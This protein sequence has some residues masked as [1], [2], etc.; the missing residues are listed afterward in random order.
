MTEVEPFAS[1]IEYISDS[2]NISKAFLYT[3]SG[4]ISL[5]IYKKIKE[6]IKSK[7]KLELIKTSYSQLGF[8]KLMKNDAFL[9]SFNFK[10]KKRSL[11]CYSLPSG[12]VNYGNNCYVN[13]F[14]QCISSLNEFIEY[15]SLEINSSIVSFTNLLRDINCSK[16][17]ILHP[18]DFISDICSQ[19]EFANEQQDSYELFHRIMD[20]YKIDE[21]S[22]PLIIK[23]KTKFYCPNCKMV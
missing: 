14:L 3:C 12:I 9:D 11:N 20:L 2:E 19:F 16:I 4:L 8:I 23:L 17:K 22:N 13:V 7:K 21:N 1:I 5:F 10:K 15:S 6:K 18:H